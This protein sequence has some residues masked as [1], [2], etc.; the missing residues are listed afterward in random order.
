MKDQ[1]S[2]VMTRVFDAPRRMVFDAYTRP[3]LLKRWLGVTV[4][5]RY[6][7]RE[8]RDGV[9]K[10]PMEGGVAESYDKLAELLASP[11]VRR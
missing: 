6:E 8:A 2:I 9:L 10:S 1:E 3:E 5:L 7:S 11:E 4:T